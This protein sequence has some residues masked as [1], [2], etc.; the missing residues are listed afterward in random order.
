MSTV[1]DKTRAGSKAQETRETTT[2]TDEYKARLEL[3]YEVAQQASS[4]SE[5]SK[6][7]E[8][9]L[10]ATQ[11]LVKASASSLLLIDEEKGGLCFQAAGGKAANTLRQIRLGL[12][13]GIA[14]WV[15][16]HGTPLVTNDVAGDKRFNKQIDEVS[17][18]VSKSIMA[19]P[20]V[21]GQGIIGVIEVLNKVD[22]SVF[23]EQDLGVLTGFASTEALILLVSMA[24][25]AIHNIKLC[26]SLQD[27]FKSTVETLVVAVDAKDPYTYGHSRRVKEYALLAANSLSFSS[28]ELQAIGFGALLHDIGKIG[29]HDSILRKSGPLMAEEWYVIHKHPLRGANIVSEI[30]LLAKARDVVLNHHERYDGNGYP[31]GLRG[32]NI[33]IGARLVA[34]ADAFDTMTT[35]RSYRL[36]LSADDALGELVKH[37]GTQFCPVAV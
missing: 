35:D 16:R 33:P 1:F 13:S 25:T 2:E 19:V 14:G 37:A 10:R 18:F 8:Q 7:L 24:A 29:I 15:A 22:G 5:V 23:T 36:K 9:I 26:E 21:R 17:G 34:V 20:L 30:S 4:A 12:D 27:G 11:R 6:L 3:L 31:E 32:E 28:E